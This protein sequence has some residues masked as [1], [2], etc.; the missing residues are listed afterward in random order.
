MYL[1]SYSWPSLNYQLKKCL[2]SFVKLE[3]CSSCNLETWKELAWY[4]RLIGGV[5]IKMGFDTWPRFVFA[6]KVS[7][8]EIIGE[9]IGWLQIQSFRSLL[10]LY[11]F[12]K[13]EVLPNIKFY[14]I[15]HYGSRRLT[16]GLHLKDQKLFCQI[17]CRAFIIQFW[18]PCKA[19]TRKEIDQHGSQ[20]L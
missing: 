11:C 10:L 3:D 15:F 9:T 7:M 4:Q 17:Y 19:L 5:L 6:C 16:G 20:L 1:C 8:D 12:K 13:V 14:T 18:L 2:G